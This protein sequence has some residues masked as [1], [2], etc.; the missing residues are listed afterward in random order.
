ME[1]LVR[2]GCKNCFSPHLRERDGKLHCIS[3]GAVFERN[4]E[5]AEERDARILYLSRLDSAEKLLRMSPPRFDDAEDHFRDFIKLYPDH[6]DGYWG[7]VRARYG[8][9]YEDDVTGR[10]IPSCYKSSY[11]DFRKDSDFMKALELAENDFIYDALQDQ[12][13]LIAGVCKEWREEAG[14]YNYDIFISFKA[15]DDKTG[16]DTLDIEDMKELHSF[17]LEEGYNV[18]F[19]PR[20]MRR[21]QGRHYDAYIFNALQTSKAMIVYGSKPEYFTSTW[22][23]N[24]W[25]RFLRMEAKGEKKPGSCIVAHKGFRPYELPPELRKIQAIDASEENRFYPDILNTIKRILSEEKKSDSNEE[26]MREIAELRKQQEEVQK[27]NQKQFEESKKQQEALKKSL[28]EKK[29][30]DNTTNKHVAINASILQPLPK[31]R[32]TTP[33]IDTDFEIKDRC[34]VKYKGKKSKIVIPAGITSIEFR[35]FKECKTLVDVTIPNSVTTIDDEAFAY[36]D[37]LTSIVIPDSVTS[38]GKE[39]FLK[40]YSLTSVVIG[41]SVT[42]IGW[43]AFEDCKNLTN[44]KIGNNVKSIDDYAFNYCF[45]LASVVIPNSVTTIGKDVFVGQT[46][47]WVQDL[48]QTKQWG[49]NW[50]SRNSPIKVIGKSKPPIKITDIIK[51]SK[52]S[53][54]EIVDGCLKEYK[55]DKAE[56]VIPYGVTS[57]GKSAF[58]YC[59]G[60]TSVVIPDS[61][62]TIEDSAFYMCRNL[63]N[64][65]IPNSVESIEWS[66]FSDCYSLESIYIPDSVICLGGFMFK[67][68]ESLVNITIDENNQYYKSVEGNVYNKDGTKLIQYA[69]GKK[70][71][72]FVIPYSVTTIGDNAFCSCSSLTSV[73]IP[74]SV[75]TIG[76]SAFLDCNKLSSVFFKNSKKWLA[77]IQY[78]G[79]RRLRNSRYVHL[80]FL[81]NAKTAAKYLTS[82]FRKCEW[83]K[84]K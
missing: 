23:Q 62:K 45:K 61:V 9:K 84:K 6:C 10:K 41:D 52:D 64:V 38:I 13:K 36:C 42:Y 46:R 24:E 78:I 82:T 32:V 25:T 20:S 18:F 28:E 22:V 54:F 74:N 69:A 27:A 60:L 43:R 55:G 39:A 17:L 63:T 83:T 65:V 68:C 2:F 19:S 56:V 71:T 26:L 11:E 79:D 72:S 16:N 4:V 73:T 51:T 49:A 59:R 50:N 5:T 77:E 3:C 66:V 57:I 53:D 81:N 40:C 76:T 37:N 75:T 8:I 7:L 48:E 21:Y 31:T 47:I 44:V 80:F 34:L 35:A 1:N 29:N 30:I 15:T 14:K 70:D 33:A 67:G 58:K 12:A